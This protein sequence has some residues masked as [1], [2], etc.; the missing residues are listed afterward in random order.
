[1]DDAPMSLEKAE[2][3]VL[4]DGAPLGLVAAA[5]EHRRWWLAQWP[6]GA[7]YV[8]G[9]LA[10]DVQEAVHA[11]DPLWPACLESSCPERFAHPMFVEPEL[12]PDPFWTC[13]RTGLPIAAVGRLLG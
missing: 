7:A 2:A 9:L 1:M 10:Q 8:V 11:R 4:R 3:A 6:D 12:G 13:H 5:V